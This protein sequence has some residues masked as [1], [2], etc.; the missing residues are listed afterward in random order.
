MR[1]Q[2]GRIE[3]DLKRDFPNGHT[4][5]DVEDLW[6]KHEQKF[7]RSEPL[8]THMRNYADDVAAALHAIHERAPSRSTPDEGQR[9][10]PRQHDPARVEAAAPRIDQVRDRNLHQAEARPAPITPDERAVVRAAVQERIERPS[11]NPTP[12][13][14]VRQV[15]PPVVSVDR[16]NDANAR[17]RPDS[18][19]ERRP[20]PLPHAR[21]VD[22]DRTPAYFREEVQA[23]KQR[24]GK[25][26][27]IVKAD[28]D[29]L[30]ASRVSQS[31]ERLAK[32][33]DAVA[34][35]REAIRP[36]D[37]T[38]A[39]LLN[40]RAL[41]LS[42][43]LNEENAARKPQH[44]PELASPRSSP[45]DG[46]QDRKQEPA[47]A[48]HR[49]VVQPHQRSPENDERTA[50]SPRQE[51][52]DQN[53]TDPRAP[54]AN[55]RPEP[56]L[57]D[58][59]DEDRT[60]VV[61]SQA[62][63]PIDDERTAAS[64]PPEV[65][66]RAPSLAPNEDRLA[67]EAPTGPLQTPIVRDVV[68]DALTQP[69]PMAQPREV[70]RTPTQPH[71]RSVEEVFTN[72]RPAPRD[73]EERA[74]PAIEAQ[75]NDV[76]RDLVPTR[77]E[78]RTAEMQNAVAQESVVITAARWR[79]THAAGYDSNRSAE[80]RERI[81]DEPGLNSYRALR[82]HLRTVTDPNEMNAV[83]QRMRDFIDN[84]D[85]GAAQRLARARTQI[86]ALSPEQLEARQA[87][88]RDELEQNPSAADVNYQYPTLIAYELGLLPATEETR[89]TIDAIHTIIITTNN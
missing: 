5:A 85:G 54:A 30:R 23:L 70:E 14:Q 10:P 81:I 6:A 49:S 24:G 79:A 39:A 48:Q 35:E 36:T 18:P 13:R 8:D 21:A 2:E 1:H 15:A 69:M 3:G 87:A 75:N 19:I 12:E 32:T 44:T 71:A 22:R 58:L 51:S 73:S 50:Q 76:F 67:R 65:A 43:L 82:E 29:T 47:A 68:E 60:G 80:A 78:A 20:E 45:I 40:V 17:P 7:P 59:L 72:E 57:Q 66:A 53:R 37:P 42:A 88:A 33:L 34:A 77:I 83:A 89:R 25:E 9:A 86:A 4:K 41:A 16:P 46:N 31:P 56:S 28:M 62:Q 84:A 61:P 38:R 27:D 26:W 55:A 63:R 74:R 11:P 52:A 64:P